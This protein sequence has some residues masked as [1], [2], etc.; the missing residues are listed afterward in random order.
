MRVATL[1]LHHESNTFAPV[2]ASL[3]QFLASGPDEGDGLIAK[4]AESQATLAGFIEAAA[5]AP[6]VDLVPLVFFDLNPM[7]TITAE[8][9]DTIITRLLAEL[10]D[11]G[12][13][14]AVLLALHGAA[15]SE[16]HRD[17]DG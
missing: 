17:A 12:P 10:D 16:V 8:A 4:Y 5:A 14:D 1:G 7:G 2:P 15:A 13:W 6:D 9:L 11:G 3:E